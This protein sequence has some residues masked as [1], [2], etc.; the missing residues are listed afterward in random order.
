[1]TKRLKVS[2]DTVF[3]PSTQAYAASSNGRRLADFNAPN[4][5]PNTASLSE[6]DLLR[7]R[8]RASL[9]NNPWIKRGILADVANEIG[10]GI[11][12]R[13]KTPNKDLNKQLR[14]LWQDWQV[15]ADAD[16]VLS[17]YGIQQ[18]C[19]RARRESGEVFIRIRQRK[20]KDG[21]IV[22]LQFQV[23]ESDF[24]P[25][26][27]HQT[28]KNGNR[29]IAG[30]EFNAI[31]KR[32]AYWMYPVHPGDGRLTQNH[33]MPMRIPAEQIIHHYIPT[34]PGQ[35]RGEPVTIQSLIKAFHFDQYDDAELERK[36]TRANYTGVIQKNFPTEEEGWKYDPITGEP[37]SDVEAGEI[38][39]YIHTEPGTFPSLLP[40]EEIHLFPGDESGQGYSDFVRQQLLGIAA[41]LGV[42]YELL[43]GDYSQIN[44][45]IWRAVM[46]QYRREIQMTQTLFTVQHICRGM[47]N[48]FVDMAVLA[49]VV[50][51]EDYSDNAH[52]YKRCDFRPQAWAY[53]HPVQ[54]V[55]SRKLEIEAGLDSR[56]SIVASRGL[57]VEEVD[58]QRA[59]DARRERD[60]NLEN[61]KENQNGKSNP[62]D[63]PPIS[64]EA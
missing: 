56:Q 22:P 63:Q 12:P 30:I 26:N 58:M 24:C 2:S 34:R 33:L 51:I 10:T 47:W 9:R 53:I 42:P 52:Q 60:L 1:M 21:L 28:L 36:K 55:Q 45:R 20:P 59:E 17:A 23:L 11:V 38:E 3:K 61:H 41:G 16:G 25:T 37:V 8:S 27:L 7:S 57:D 5:G 54:D 39:N 19:A 48:A 4:L 18:I 35:I 64:K 31:G 46:N 44:D 14:Q 13:P 6:L 32:V 50:R 15:S 29:I 43:T 49:G 40:G 62:S